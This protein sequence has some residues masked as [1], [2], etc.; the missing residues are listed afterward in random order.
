SPHWPPRW[1]PEFGSVWL[2]ETV[3]RVLP[4]TGRPARLVP[5]STGERSRL[6]L[7]CAAK[8][9]QRERDRGERTERDQCDAERTPLFLRESIRG[10]QTDAE[11]EC[12]A[13][14]RN[15]PE[16]GER[17]PG[18]FDAAHAQISFKGH[19]IFDSIAGVASS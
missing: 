3:A 12:A 10:E 1:A 17:D 9:F 11:T 5:D 13:R 6:L 8:Y 18:L 2:R 14:R 16:N 19:A 15:E 4:S 7:A